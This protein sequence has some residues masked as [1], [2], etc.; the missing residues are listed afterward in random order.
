MSLTATRTPAAAIRVEAEG[1]ADAIRALTHAAFEA[2]PHA[3]G[4]EPA[5]IDALRVA[6]ALSLS[7]VAC[8]DGA[9]GHEP[10]LGH[11]AFSPVSIESGEAGWYG[12]GPLSVQPDRQREGIGTALVRD[13]LA[14]LRKMGARGC[15]LI[16][17]PAYYARFGFENR[18]GLTYRGL[19]EDYVQRLVITPPAPTGEI[20]YHPAF[21]TAL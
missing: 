11:I 19:P 16:G 1:D 9:D 18:A 8:E 6:D 3:S 7:L 12:L 15:V 14:R 13:G 4:T 5:I 21:E 20:H 2:A 10:I 17:D